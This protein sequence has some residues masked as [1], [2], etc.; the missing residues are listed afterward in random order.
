MIFSVM[1]IFPDMISQL[2]VGFHQL[3]VSILV[4]IGLVHLHDQMCWL[5][6]SMLMSMKLLALMKE[7]ANE[8]VKPLTVL[9]N[10]LF[11][12]EKFL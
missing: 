10:N 12:L 6:C 7:V 9:Y 5:N 11:S 2:V 1:L 3:I 8:I 4:L